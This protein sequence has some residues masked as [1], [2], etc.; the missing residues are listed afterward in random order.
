MLN[1]DKMGSTIGLKALLG[2]KKSFDGGNNEL[3]FKHYQR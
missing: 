2:T 3:I 1:K